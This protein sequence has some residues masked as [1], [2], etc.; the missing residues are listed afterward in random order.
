MPSWLLVIPVLSLLV[1]IHELGHFLT[2]K[3][4]G[5]KVTEFGFGFPPRIW[6]ITFGE[7]RYSINL[8]P[9][10]GFVK[11][12]GEE[13]PTEPRSFARQSILK[14]SIVLIA[15]SFMNL[16][17]PIIIF[18]I[19]LTL[20]HDTLV[21]TVTIS[22]VAPNSPAEESGLRQGDAILEVNS[23][24]ISNHMD[25][26]KEISR[27]KGTKVELL[28][29]KN[30]SSLGILGSPEFT[31]SEY[32]YITPRINPP[33]LKVVNEVSIPEEEIELSKAQ[34]YNPSLEI[35]DT[36]QQG[37]LGVLIGTSNGKI[38][39]DSLPLQ[40]SIPTSFS[41]M[42]DVISF[43][44]QGI[45]N[46]FSKGENP[47]LTGPI[48]IAQV[49]GEVAKVGI[50]PIFELTALISISLGI[51]NLLP[52]PALDGGRLM[53]VLLEGIRG[54]RRI[55]PEKEGFIHLAGFMLLIGLVVVMSY[56][57][58]VR[59]ISGDSFFR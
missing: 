15:G 56:F 4:F 24:K 2:A 1:F 14:R 3:K 28:V 16:I 36:L 54:G 50:A 51:V 11:M 55:S 8:I 12:V 37:S 39:K 40:Q 19:I 46:L 53:F 13:D 34:Q 58:I 44:A 7:T 25:L 31:S 43:S 57:D 29:R 18:T 45:G 35:G 21:G 20:P 42:G 41:K 27:L 22:G 38:I 33:S 59:I 49:T 6:G 10:G 32:V 17:L 23:L 52:I 26:V 47:G 30:G 5:I 9:L 48:G